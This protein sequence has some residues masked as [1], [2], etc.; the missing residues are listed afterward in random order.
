MGKWTLVLVGAL[1]S[2]AVQFGLL[3]GTG[4]TQTLPL[5]AGVIGAVGAAVLG[6]MKQLPREEWSEEQRKEMK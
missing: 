3:V 6:L 5:V 1:A 4:V 2:G